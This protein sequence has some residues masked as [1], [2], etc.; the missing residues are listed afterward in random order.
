MSGGPAPTAVASGG[1]APFV[2]PTRA[3]GTVKLDA[4][5]TGGTLS[6]FE[7][8]MESGEGPGVHV[9][10]REHELWYVLEGEFRFLLGDE[11][12]HQPTGGLA[13]GPRGTPHT[14]QNTGAGTGRLLV[15]TAPSGLEEFFLAYDRRATGPHDAEALEEAARVG[16]LDFVGPPLSVSAPTSQ[17]PPGG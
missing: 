7:L 16:G 13:F 17:R 3:S 9:H 15:V 6:V 5:G 11:L 14:F 2:L 1:G 10:R 8:V 4:T 12:V